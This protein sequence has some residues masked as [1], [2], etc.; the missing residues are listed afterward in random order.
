MCHSNDPHHLRLCPDIFEGHGD[1]EE[2]EV[3]NAFDERDVAEERDRIL[4]WVHSFF[5]RGK[6]LSPRGARGT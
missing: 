1:E 3:G 4:K 5:S 2:D 6:S